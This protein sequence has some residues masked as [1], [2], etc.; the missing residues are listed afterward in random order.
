M[1]RK[2]YIFAVLS[3]VALSVLIFADS[4]KAQTIMADGAVCPPRFVC[5]K[6][7]VTSAAASTYVPGTWTSQYFGLTQ[8]Q[9][10]IWK[11][12]N[13]S[14]ALNID[15]GNVSS[16]AQYETPVTSM[17]A[18]QYQ[19]NEAARTANN[20]ALRTTLASATNNVVNVPASQYLAISCKYAGCYYTGAKIINTGVCKNQTTFE[21]AN[22]AADIAGLSQSA[23][24]AIISP[25]T[26]HMR[27]GGTEGS[28]DTRYFSIIS[29]AGTSLSPY[30]ANKM[31]VFDLCL[32]PNYISNVPAGYDKS[33]II[34]MN[35]PKTQLIV[36]PDATQSS[37]QIAGVNTSRSF[38]LTSKS[39]SAGNT[40]VYIFHVDNIQQIVPNE[41]GVS[42]NS[43]VVAAKL[44]SMGYR[45]A[46]K[47]EAF[48]IQSIAGAD[49]DGVKLIGEPNGYATLV[50]SNL[51]P[52]S[53]CVASSGLIYNGDKVAAVKL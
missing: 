10:D 49:G 3:I 25:S 44:A 35:T 33:A 22:R 42:I 14:E 12:S 18:E 11:A 30:P 36:L 4:L 39:Y 41:Q 32:D 19:A 37:V 26:L 29:A 28:I 27:Y 15:Y 45:M 48:A 46:T 7:S 13:G 2:Y 16:Q 9:V 40:T 52:G 47:T 24:A 34:S 6:S 5:K 51:C 38:G 8:E 50:M 43:S 20:A 31:Y 1:N 53:N 21:A 17:T 23:R